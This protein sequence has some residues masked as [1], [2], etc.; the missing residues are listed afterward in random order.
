MQLLRQ[1]NRRA[2]VPFYA[3]KQIRQSGFRYF[4]PEEEVR[5]SQE[6]KDAEALYRQ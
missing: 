5:Q 2:Q 6:E 4:L 3:E 1:A